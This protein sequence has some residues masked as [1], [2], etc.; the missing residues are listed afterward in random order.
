[1]GHEV[2]KIGNSGTY[3]R[4]EKHSEQTKLKSLQGRT[5]ASALGALDENQMTT[6]ELTDEEIMSA[7]L[8]RFNSSRFSHSLFNTINSGTG[9]SSSSSSSYQSSLGT[10]SPVKGSEST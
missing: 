2:G 4:G 8:E 7:E 10:P 3:T 6:R 1:M 5:S 9:R